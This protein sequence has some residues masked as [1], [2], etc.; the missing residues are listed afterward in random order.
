MPSAPSS[1]IAK[2]F[3]FVSGV[4]FQRDAEGGSKGK[5]KAREQEF[6]NFGR[7]LPKSF[8]VLREKSEF[9][10]LRGC[11]KAVIIGVH[12]WFPGALFALSWGW[13]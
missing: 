6:R 8:D 7:E 9:D 10:A 2:T 11:S 4:L 1:T 5:G 13:H 12:G 3:S